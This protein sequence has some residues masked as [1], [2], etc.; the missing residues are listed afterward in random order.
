M[1]YKRGP[2]AGRSCHLGRRCRAHCAHVIVIA[3]W[4]VAESSMGHASRPLLTCILYGRTVYT[5]C[6]TCIQ[7]CTFVHVSVVLCLFAYVRFR[8]RGLALPS[9]CRTPSVQPEGTPRAHLPLHQRPATGAPHSA[10]HWISHGLHAAR[11]LSETASGT[12]VRLRSHSRI[13][14]HSPIAFRS[15]YAD[16]LTNANDIAP[17]RKAA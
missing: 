15:M 4:S 7:Y 16:Y 10:H 6:W 8:R 11:A 14:F 3:R 1:A 2:R 5:W 13:Y 17:G 12:G 9:T